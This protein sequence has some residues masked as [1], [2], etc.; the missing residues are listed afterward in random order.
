MTHG[1]T[2][3]DAFVLDCSDGVHPP[4]PQTFGRLGPRNP[5]S[6]IAPNG[7]PFDDKLVQEAFS[8]ALDEMRDDGDPEGDVAAGMT[9]FGQFI[10]HDITL[11]AQ[12]AIGTRIDPRA[13]RNVRTPG[14]DLDC[15][16][17]DGHEASPYLYHPEHKGYLLF[18]TAENP[19][20][21]ARNSHGTAIIGDFRNDENQ[22]VSQLQGA[23]VCMHNILMTA[24]QKDESLVPDA[25]AGIRSEAL[26]S[27]VEGSEMPFEAA[28][29]ILR[30]HYHWIILN[31]FLPA[32]VDGDVLKKVLHA[33]DHGTLP[34]PYTAHA[35][36][37][38]IEFSGAA[39]RFGHATVQNAYELNGSSGK[40]KLFDMRRR[41]FHSRPT[42]LNVEFHRLFNVPGEASAQAARP[43]GR[44][45][46]STIFA[47]P[48]IDGPLTIGGNEL[49]LEDSRKLP[50]R[51]V[52]RD[53]VTLELPSGQQMARMMHVPEIAAPEELRAHGI[54]KTPLWYYC[55]HEAE[56]H[57]GKLG[58]V[59][60]TIVAT[61]LVRLM[62]LD[63]ESIL[64]STHDFKPWKALGA[65]EDGSF[66]LGHMLA[67]V[68][69]NRDKV[70][71]RDDLLT[72][73]PAVAAAPELEDA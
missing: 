2:G 26:A 29:R 49:S 43:I 60:G 37:M 67:C 47:L 55:L 22:I 21:L 10:D 63:P 13:I 31:D 19:Y 28:R 54:T 53:R 48:F 27:G 5:L 3:Y 58:P 15:V 51:N 38:P 73:T 7:K 1:L 24:L 69:T 30:L 57:G 33:F 40:V 62:A 44:K 17:G 61:T 12:S 25:L 8:A 59:G 6:G 4:L 42:E 34:K 14:L 70:A 68:E 46:A 45:L 66:S 52:F 36:I 32:F 64:C 50:H 65:G 11:D 16:Y 35:P 56:A 9:F 72:G 20:D 18:G 41:E 23:F 39:Y 71:H